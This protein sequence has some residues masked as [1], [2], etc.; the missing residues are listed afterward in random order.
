[1][2]ESDKTALEMVLETDE[3]RSLLLAEQAY[4]EKFLAVEAERVAKKDSKSAAPAA[5]APPPAT[6]AVAATAAATTSETE[7][8]PAVDGEWNEGGALSSLLLFHP[9]AA[10]AAAPALPEAPMYTLKSGQQPFERL[11]EIYDRLN[12]VCVPDTANHFSYAVFYVS[13]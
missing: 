8:V 9:P 13:D 11:L 5:A 3:E 4:W 1:M 12:E 6:A 7:A 2:P 10:S